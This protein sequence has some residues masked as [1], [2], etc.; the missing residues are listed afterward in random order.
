MIEFVNEGNLKEVM[1]LIKAYQEF[2]EVSDIDD[3]R[4]EG[5]FS[6]FGEQNP[7]GCQFLYR[8]DGRVVA[9]ATVYFSFTSTIARKVGVM[10]DL[11]VVS[12]V[13][14]KG[15]G[16]ALINHC[17]D[18]ALSKGAYRLQWV[19]AMDNQVAQRLYDSLNTNKKP[20]LFYSYKN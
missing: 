19:T 6:Q 3:D 13:R 18:Y 7:F 8:I 20:W 14:G 9:F 1:P 12:D 16:R 17:L 5:F 10:N 15:I 11:F 4:N 2:Y